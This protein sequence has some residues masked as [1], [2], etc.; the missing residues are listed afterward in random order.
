MVLGI[1]KKLR[2]RIA[3]SSFSKKTKQWCDKYIAA[4]DGTVL[5]SS[6]FASYFERYY[7]INHMLDFCVGK[8]SASED[9]F[10]D[11]ELACAKD[12]FSNPLKPLNFSLIK[13]FLKDLFNT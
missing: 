12:A 9:D 6:D 8:V 5:T 1:R 3:L 7:V 11:E 13:S 2:D 4:H 10:L